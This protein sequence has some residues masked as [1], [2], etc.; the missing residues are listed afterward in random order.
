MTNK[1][2]YNDKKR[3]LNTNAI[4]KTF[5]TMLSKVLS[6]SIKSACAYKELIRY[7]ETAY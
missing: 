5:N 3:N 2:Q 4:I 1:L 7:F 6:P